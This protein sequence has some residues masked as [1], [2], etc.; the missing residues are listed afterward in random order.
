MNANGKLLLKGEVYAIVGAAIEVLNELGHGL[1]EKPYENAL[2]VEFGRQR[3]SFVQQR[4]YD[5]IY[6]SVK[7]GE[8]ILDLIV[9][10]LV[11]VDAKV[12]DTITDHERGQM[13]NYLKITGLKVGVTSNGQNSNGS[14]SCWI[15]GMHDEINP[16]NRRVLL[17]V[18]V[19]SR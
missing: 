13:L 18:S 14:E 4:R 8:Y 5:I 16:F 17:R 15:R 6:K 11:V 9:F 7:V 3:I 19:N 1:H 10:G 12:I 2:L